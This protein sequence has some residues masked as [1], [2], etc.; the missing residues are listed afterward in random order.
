MKGI[1]SL[2]K[3]K[4]RELS[5]E[6]KRLKELLSKLEELKLKEKQVNQKIEEIK[7]WRARTCIEFGF[8]NEYSKRLFREID[9]LR[10][11]TVKL[12]SEIERQ[13]EK[14]ALKRGEVKAVEKLVERRE[15]EKLK[16]EEL[17]L[18]RFINEVL[19]SRTNA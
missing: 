13:K 1:K 11:K 8:M 2:L 5:E 10:R 16:K 4:R 3:V 18:E 12:S 17:L 14:L 7:R 19:N 15:K 9:A 6:E